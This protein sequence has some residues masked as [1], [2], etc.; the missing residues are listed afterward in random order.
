MR[1]HGQITAALLMTALA[2]VGC[3]TGDEQSQATITPPQESA[4]MT[5][6]SLNT[7]GPLTPLDSK[8]SEPPKT[9]VPASFADGE[10][11]Y[12]TGNYGEATKVFEGYTGKHP[13]NAWGHYMLGLSAWKS[14]DPAKAETAF[15]E[16]LRIDPKHVKSM[17][18]LSRVL[19]DE[20][21]FDD[22]LGVLAR[23][24]GIDPKSA[25]THRLLG[26][27]NAA[28]G[29]T[30]DAVTSYRRAITLDEKDAWS[31]NNLGLL[32]LEQ[33]RHE[34]ALPL[35]A[36]AV[37]LN[38]DVPVFP[39]NL[40]MAL[41]RTKHFKAAAEAYKG[42]LNA[43]PNF[44]KAKRNLER[45]EAVKTQGEDPFDLDTTAKRFV[46]HQLPSDETVTVK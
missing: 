23:A 22:A 6:A 42:A 27:A 36:R 21:R 10:T 2:A 5:P 44:E 13:Q 26:R 20:K 24:E 16:A 46:E 8:P 37:Q 18:N 32:Y 19:I 43:D 11:A 9:V 17:V 12:R 4:K 35:L 39:N 7:S 30:D 41:E 14:G 33:Q 38:K 31:M 29:K 25:D 3:S 28:S 15:N 45:V 1:R 40:G 34:D